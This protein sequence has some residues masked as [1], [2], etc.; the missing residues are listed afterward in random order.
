MSIYEKNLSALKDV[1]PQLATKLSKIKTNERYEVFASGHYADANILDT[2]DNQ[3][4]YERRPIDEIEENYIE[5]M[6]KYKLYKI[7]YV[8]GIGNGHLC[9]MLL[10][11][12]F[13]NFLYIFEPNIELLYIALNL[14]DISADIES[15]RVTLVDTTDFTSIYFREI[16]DGVAVVHFKAYTMLLNSGFYNKYADDMIKVNKEILKIFQYYAY[17][18]GNDVNDELLGLKHFMQ[19]LPL[20]IENP[21]LVNLKKK[22]SNTETAIIVATGPSLAKQLPYLRE[23]KDY[24]TIIAADASLPVLEKEGIKPDIVTTIERT[25]RTGEFYEHT[26]V[27]FQKDIVFALTAIVAQELIDNINDGQFQFSMRPTGWHYSYLELDEYG[28]LGLGMSA[29]NMAYELASTMQ[30]K[31]I[32]IIGQDLA[33]GR[34]GSSHSKNHIFGTEE[35]KDN[36]IDGTVTAYGGEGEINTTKVWRMFLTGYEN[37]VAQ[38]NKNKNNK[39]ITINSTEGGARIAGTQE[40]PFKE[41]LDKYVDKTSKKD[42]IDL[43]K[44]IHF[45]Y[46]KNLKQVNEKLDSALKLGYDMRNEA[47]KILKLLTKIINRHKKYD[48]KQIHKH[49]KEKKTRGA[50]DKLAVI[51][52]MYYKKEFKQFYESLISPL[53][54]HLEYNIA[55]ESLQIETT[56]KDR[57]HKNW[58]MILF[59]H[60]WA[61]RIVIALDAIFEII[62]PKKE[63]LQKLL[64]KEIDEVKEDLDL[65]KESK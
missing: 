13:L 28:Y 24:V 9:N 8:Y 61:S 15:K 47:K 41:A 30:F 50:V 34:D 39:F 21:T 14:T 40:I 32:I 22:G 26:S 51:R 3:F 54:V 57:I 43:D 53:L 37:T 4:M 44:P 12:K 2:Q 11:N 7:L 5:I 49:I 36:K 10:Q 64:D 33:Y 35:I 63:N 23:I 52:D 27:E 65:M 56:K 17:S 45:E 62:E 20:M 59:H 60:E 29:A 58:K 16:V 46:V 55:Y 25:A 19:N 31:Q 38:N 42:K 6:K 18:S 48:I 1:N